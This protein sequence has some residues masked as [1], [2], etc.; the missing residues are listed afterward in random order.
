[1]LVSHTIL[2][3][4][5][6]SIPSITSKGP[7]VSFGDLKQ[8]AFACSG[9]IIL[10]SHIFDKVLPLL[11]SDTVRIFYLHL[12]KIAKEAQSNSVFSTLTGLQQS[13][14][15]APVKIVFALNELKSL[16]PSS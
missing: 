10:P 13:S 1:M 8:L 6:G 16:H 11:S 3:F 12:W 2:K 5:L 4:H 15:L 14:G 9:E 7:Q